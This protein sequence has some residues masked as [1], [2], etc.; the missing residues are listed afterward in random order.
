MIKRYVTVVR[1][2]FHSPSSL[3]V[4]EPGPHVGMQTSPD[5]QLSMVDSV[6]CLRFL[7]G[8][9]FDHGFDIFGKRA[10]DHMGSPEVVEYCSSHPAAVS[11]PTRKC[12]WLG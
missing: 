1:M 6:A 7:A 11:N 8:N 12:R 9:D 10:F 3:V 4:Y 2:S 5:S